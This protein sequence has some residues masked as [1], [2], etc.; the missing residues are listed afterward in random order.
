M[1]WGTKVVRFESGEKV[2]I[3]NVVLEAIHSAIIKDYV[4]TTKEHNR[5]CS[6]DE[7][8]KIFGARTYRRWLKVLAILSSCI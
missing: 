3:G 2:K 1:A 4:S 5:R 8:V 7:V 6:P